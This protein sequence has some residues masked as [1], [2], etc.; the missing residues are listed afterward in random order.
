MRDGSLIAE[1]HESA[2]P[3]LSLAVLPNQMFV[4]GRQDGTC[5]VMSLLKGHNNIRVQL[6]GSDCDG[7]R[8][9]AFNGKWIFACCR[10]TNI[11]KYDFNQVIVHFK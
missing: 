10:D 3:V 5:T 8:D 1:W 9:I 11:R 6:T 4:I 2:N 7:I